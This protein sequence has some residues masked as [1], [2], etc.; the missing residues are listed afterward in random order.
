MAIRF[1]VEA[2]VLDV[3][4]HAN[5]FG[6]HVENRHVN[7]SSNGVLP[8]KVFARKILVDHDGL[9]RMLVVSGGDESAS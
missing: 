2:P 4:H 3:P 1:Q 8:R 5:D 6:V 7:A 9:G